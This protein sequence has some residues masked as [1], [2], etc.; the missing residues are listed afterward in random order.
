MNVAGLVSA[1]ERADLLEALVRHAMAQHAAIEPRG[2]DSVKARNQL[3]VEIDRLL[4]GWT[5]ERAQAE[6]EAASS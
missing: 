5:V 1:Q 2:F 4:D 3:H 6:L